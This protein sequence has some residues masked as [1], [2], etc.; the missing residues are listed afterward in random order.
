MDAD[1][2]RA[3]EEEGVCGV[4][5]G[6]YSEGLAGGRSVESMVA[7]WGYLYLFGCVLVR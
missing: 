4:G 5:E 7:C 1:D 6:G 3:G 2:L